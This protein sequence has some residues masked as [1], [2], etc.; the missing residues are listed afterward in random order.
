M[1]SWHLKGITEFSNPPLIN[2]W[3]PSTVPWTK[4]TMSWGRQQPQGRQHPCWSNG[5]YISSITDLASTSVEGSPL[6]TPVSLRLWLFSVSV[7]QFSFPHQHLPLWS[8]QLQTLSPLSSLPAAERAEMALSHTPR[9]VTSVLWNSPRRLPA[10]R[11]PQ[12]RVPASRAGLSCPS[13]SV[14]SY[15]E[16]LTL[17]GF[18]V[19]SFSAE[20]PHDFVPPSPCPHPPPRHDLLPTPCQPSRWRWCSGSLGFWGPLHLC[21]I[22]ASVQL[23]LGTLHH[24]FLVSHCLS[25][26]PLSLSPASGTVKPHTV[27]SKGCNSLW[28]TASYS[29]VEIPWCNFSLAIRKAPSGATEKQF[30]YFQVAG[31]SEVAWLQCS[32]LRAE[33]SNF[34]NHSSDSRISRQF[35]TWDLGLSSME[36][37]WFCVVLY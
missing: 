33:F 11:T 20:N 30:E 24:D 4:A 29:C 3:V 6:N 14:P 32:L 26:G 19:L 37:L 23:S 12:V 16:P 13:S 36:D 7:A 25:N 35:S 28:K 2:V 18:S 9:W 27:F 15:F 34:L 5:A 21:S 17:S 10:D 22:S 31:M 8:A 1:E